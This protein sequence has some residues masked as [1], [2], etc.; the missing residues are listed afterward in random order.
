MCGL[1]KPLVEFGKGKNWCK[2]CRNAYE[3]RRLSNP[4]KRE[5]N[6]RRQ[7]AWENKNKDANYKRRKEREKAN[8]E[9]KHRRKARQYRWYSNNTAY[10]QN[11]HLKKRYGLTLDERN[12]L[13]VRQ[14]GCASC[15]SLDPASKNG[16]HVDHCHR[17]GRVRGVVCQPC[18]LMIGFAE[19]STAILEQCA[20][21][22]ESR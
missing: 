19:E 14:G 1:L 11:L 7:R 5:N 17:T 8:P 12:S 13:L 21:Y 10:Y 20:A 4:E 2:L 3:R 9:L 15:G 6:R 18:N 22:L 16:W